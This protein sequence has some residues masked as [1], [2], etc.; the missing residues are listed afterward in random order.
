MTDKQ[1]CKSED[2]TDFST[3][4]PYKMHMAEAK[5]F[6]EHINGDGKFALIWGSVLT[7]EGEWDDGISRG[8]A[9]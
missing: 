8:P 5:E 6:H 2:G 1:N 3:L 9:T 7:Q 4:T